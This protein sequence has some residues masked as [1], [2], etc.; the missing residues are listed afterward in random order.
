MT[1]KYL[2]PKF[3]IIVVDSDRHTLREAARRG[4]DSI[5]AQTFRDFE[6][7]FV[8]NGLKELPYEEEFDLS[9]LEK[10][11]TIYIKERFND[12]GNT[13]RHYGSRVAGGEYFLFFNIDN[14]LYPTCLERVNEFLLKD[15]VRKEMVIFTIIHNKN[16]ER[17]L[18]GNPVLFQ[19]IDCLQVVASKQA[20][21]SIGFWD[22]YEYEAD[23]HLFLELSAKNT[24][25]YIEEILAENF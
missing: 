24:P 8:H 25:F 3:S 21:E 22:R 23:A 13:S 17:I 4:I 14:L 6:V 5:L 18:T 10:V 9:A 15:N 2:K 11:K 19:H 7:I 16:A 12:W 1:T 20:W